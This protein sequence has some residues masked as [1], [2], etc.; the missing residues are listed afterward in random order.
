MLVLYYLLLKSPLLLLIPYVLQVIPYFFVLKKMGLNKLNALVPFLAE[1]QFSKKLF[2]KI[3]SFFRPFI[4]ASFLVGAAYYLDPY[5]GIGI[6]YLIGGFIIYSLFL[7]RLYWRLVKSFGKKAFFALVTLV[8][9]VPFLL[10]LGLGKSEFTQP[11][12]KPEETNSKNWKNIVSISMAIVEVLVVV[13]GGGF[14]AY[15]SRTPSFF[16]NKDLEEAYDLTKNTKADG[17]VVTREDVLGTDLDAIIKNNKGRDYYFADHKNDKNVNVFVYMVGADLEDLHGLASANIT[18]ML[19]ATQMGSNLK[20]VLQTGG[21]NRWFTDGIDSASYGRY[22]IQNGKLTKIESLPSDT[23]MSKEATLTDFLTWANQN[24]TDR[25]MLVLW[26]HGGGF[27]NGYGCDDLNGAS[28]LDSDIIPMNSVA[29]ALEKSKSKFDMIGFDACLMQDIEVAK[30]MEPYADYFL[31]SEEVEG[32]YGWFYTVPFG[33]LAKDPTMS[34][35]EFGKQLIAVY[36]PYNTSVNEGEK[37]TK[38]TLSFVDLTLINSAYDKLDAFFKSVADVIEKDP[39]SF[40]EVSIAG[41][42]TYDFQKQQEDLIGFLKNLDAIDYDDSIYTTEQIQDVIESVEAS[43]LYRNANSSEGI[44]GMAFAFPYKQLTSYNNTHEQLEK[45]SFKNEEKV[46]DIF[47][48]ITV[49]QQQKTPFSIA[50]IDLKN[51]EDISSAIDSILDILVDYTKEAWY[52]PGFE[53]YDDTPQY[54]DIPLEEKETGYQVNLPEKAWDII[55]D[56]QTKVYQKVDENGAYLKALG[57]N[58][59]GGL[60]EDGHYLVSTDDHWVHVNGQ[61]VSY[62]SD[63]VQ[64][65]DGK[66]KYT[67]RIKARLNNEEDINILVEWDDA[68]KAH[69]VGYVK[70]V[71]NSFLED[72]GTLDLVAGDSIEFLFDY[73]N[74]EGNFIETRTS[75]KK[76]RV[77]KQSRLKVE[78]QKME[79]CT[80]LFGGILKDVYQRSMT[81][82]MIEYTVK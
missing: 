48:S 78:N 59:F 49:A 71:E 36:D 30:L 23:N 55:A 16:V 56:A 75:G 4:A 54:V 25:N 46:F 41:Q 76:I 33:N 8:F 42:N 58:Y 3:V 81:T 32:G 82:E 63:Q 69:V 68:T 39:K 28:L 57:N 26:N 74:E 2:P 77:T 9:P 15:Q 47:F 37:D 61:I 40:A 24:Y 64:V 6:L 17:G 1:Y 34:T 50:D 19:E 73:Y 13:F 66:E 43:V 44:N 18:Q 35:E 65:V 53:D 45:N 14:F 7:I 79:P 38:A 20:F 52:I 11:A 72:K 51:I 67:G 27:A 70:D 62:E 12:F 22:E 60:D 5:K 80:I 21:A 31:A 10:V 29:K